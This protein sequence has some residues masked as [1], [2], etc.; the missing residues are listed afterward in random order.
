MIFFRKVEKNFLSSLLFRKNT[1]NRKFKV[2]NH[3]RDHPPALA[4][5]NTASVGVK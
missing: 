4:M 3:H 1:E 2:N 5:S